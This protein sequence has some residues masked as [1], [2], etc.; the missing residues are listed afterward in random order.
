MEGFDSKIDNP[1]Y[2]PKDDEKL[3]KQKEYQFI[4]ENMNPEDPQK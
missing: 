3:M 4:L 1:K 2:G